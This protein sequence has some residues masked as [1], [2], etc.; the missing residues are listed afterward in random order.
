MILA[1]E[2]FGCGSETD[3]GS[4]QGQLSFE[5]EKVLVMINQQRGYH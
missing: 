5:V 3:N 1:D 2:A 4:G